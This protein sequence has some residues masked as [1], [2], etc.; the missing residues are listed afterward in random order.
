MVSGGGVNKNN[1][2]CM[3]W[4]HHYLKRGSILLLL[5]LLSSLISLNV[6]ASDLLPTY[7]DGRVDLSLQKKTSQTTLLSQVV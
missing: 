1:F 2:W 5:T 6:T 7:P 3:H 4:V